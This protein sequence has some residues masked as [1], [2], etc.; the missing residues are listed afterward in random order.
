MGMDIHGV[1]QKRQADR[2][3]DISS[4]YDQRRD[5]YLYCWLSS[6]RTAGL[7]PLSRPRGLPDDFALDSDGFHPI[8][9]PDVLPYFRKFRDQHTDSTRLLMGEW[10]FSWLLGSEVIAA[11][12]PID[13]MKIWVP[14]DTYNEWDKVSNPKLWYELHSDWKQ[15]EDSEH[16]ATPE[17]ISE[18][19]YWVI[20]EWSY[21][22]T[23]DFKYF[24]GEIQ[25]LMALH[26]EVRFVFGFNR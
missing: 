8:E 16:Y 7:K 2:W 20:I 19:T 14:I 13:I 15:H 23:E 6:T 4:D 17:N 18:K 26:G 3:V 24:V 9:N 10:G 21:D 12:P 11:P 5:E 22:F 25:R 1:F